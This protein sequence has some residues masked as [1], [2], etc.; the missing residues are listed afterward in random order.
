MTRFLTA[1]QSWALKLTLDRGDPD[2]ERVVVETGG[3]APAGRRGLRD[4][5]HKNP[6]KLDPPGRTERCTALYCAVLRYTAL[7]GSIV[8]S[9]IALCTPPPYLSL[10]RL[11]DLLR[12]AIARQSAYSDRLTTWSRMSRRGIISPDLDLQAP[13]GI[14]FSLVFTAQRTRNGF[15]RPTGSGRDLHQQTRDGVIVI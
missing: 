3:A 14:R 7:Y 13:A 9:C 5:R 2:N 11:L 8:F 6:R 12:N 10:A 1:M 4:G 15:L